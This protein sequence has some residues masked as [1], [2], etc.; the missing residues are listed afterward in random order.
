ML[1]PGRQVGVVHSAGRSVIRGSVAGGGKR[2]AAVDAVV[3]GGVARHVVNARRRSHAVT[4]AA[5][6][7]QAD[8]AAGPDAQTA[9]AAAGAQRASQR[10]R[11]VAAL[12]VN[13]G[14]TVPQTL[15]LAASVP[16]SR[17]VLRQRRRGVGPEP[18]EVLA[19]VVPRAE[20]LPAAPR[21]PPTSQR[22][23]VQPATPPAAPIRRKRFGGI[24]SPRSVPIHT[25]VAAA[26]RAPIVSHVWVIEPVHQVFA[27]VHVPSRE[28]VIRLQ[29]RDP[30]RLSQS[31]KLRVMIGVS[32]S[33]SR[34]LT[35]DH[36]IVHRVEKQ[37]GL[38]T[39]A[40]GL[41]RHQHRADT[42]R[43]RASNKTST[44]I[45]QLIHRRERNRG[46]KRVPKQKH[47]LRIYPR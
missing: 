33:L 12:G 39:G 28:G 11:G 30:A 35:T 14:E 41:A 34:S 40:R 42:P 37:L 19:V 20:M 17:R 5:L 2:D 24:R 25:L 45:A 16:S 27:H 22:M 46:T 4:R 36:H 10:V 1:V 3:G 44:F 6:R 8:V 18:R 38:T 29:H 13:R 21:A 31:G 26:A 32:R 15:P 47:P 9:A 43:V 7:V 23:P